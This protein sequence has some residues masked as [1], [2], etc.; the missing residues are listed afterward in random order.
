ATIGSALVIGFIPALLGRLRPALASGLGV[1]EAS[2]DRLRTGY[3]LFLVPMMVSAGLAV[4]RF[5]AREVLFVGNLLAALGIAILGLR[6]SFHA[7]FWVVLVLA[8]AASCLTC[9]GIT[10]MPRAFWGVPKEGVVEW[11]A[12]INLGFIAVGLGALLMPALCELL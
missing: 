7:T 12:S 9:A 4:D 3:F 10:L 2:V 11:A 6:P 5:E 8:V 1:A